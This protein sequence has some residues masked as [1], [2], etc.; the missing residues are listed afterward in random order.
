MPDVSG[1]TL[2]MAVQAVQES[3]ATLQGRLRSGEGD[4]LDDTEMLLAYERAADELR[5][6]YEIARLNT[7]NLPP[8]EDLVAAD[9]GD[10][11]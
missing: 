1:N 10:D 2:M 8:W 3:I 5:R 7:G 11:G 4:E 9:D 6:A